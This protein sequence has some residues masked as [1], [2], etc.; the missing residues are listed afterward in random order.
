V[1]HHAILRAVPFPSLAAG[2]RSAR[3]PAASTTPRRADPWAA[4]GGRLAARAPKLLTRA[5]IGLAL[6][7]L[8]AAAALG[9]LRTAH[10]GRVYPAIHVADLALGGMPRAEAEAALQA[11][12]AAVEAAPVVFQHEGREW[13]SS[14]GELGVRVDAAAAFA[15]AY[16]LGR[17]ATALDRLRTTA[18]LIHDDEQ[19]PLPVRFD[20]A[21]L[22]RWY[23]AIDRELGLPPREARLAIDGAR[24]AIA[25]EI[26]GTVVDRA[27]A[28]EAIVGGLH[29]LRAFAGPLPTVAQPA[30]IRAADLEPARARLAAALAKPVQ[31]SFGEGVWSLPGADLARF[32]TQ[33]VDPTKRGAEALT[34][35]I[36]RPGLAA[37]L[38]ERL[39]PEINREPKDAVV[40]WGG[41]GL[42]S[43]EWSVDG[44]EL[45]AEPLAEAVERS[46]FGDHVPV[47][48]PV[49]ITPPA[50]DS[51]NLDKLGVVTLL[52]SGT[53]NY[54]GSTDGRAHNVE[55]GT[56][57]MNGTL[58]P[59]GGEFSFNHSIGVINEANGFVEAQV[60][61]G[62]QIGQDIGGGICQVSTTVF[63]AAYLAGLPIGEW[64]PHRF[65]I[66]FY[67][68]DGWAP[69]L[70]ASILQP[71]EDPSTWADFTFTNP[72]P[73]SWLLV[74]SWVAN[75]QVVVN[76]YGAD[77]GYTV[78][79]DGPTYGEK[80][81]MLPD[82]EIV[83]DELETGQYKQTQAAKEGEEL[84]HYRRV[85]DRDG[86][87]VSEKNFYTKFWPS[88]N[89][90]KVA[91][92]MKGKSPADPDRPLPPISKPTPS[93]AEIEE[94]EAG[95]EAQ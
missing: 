88:G 19:I 41:E 31:V 15:A 85:Y 27:R 1:R 44:V 86:N 58:V 20:R 37:W 83:D 69:G 59:P 53:S 62:E 64:H 7:L 54:S 17:E 33:E 92:D 2:P 72:S 14:L 74:E 3:R 32:V 91:P 71:T 35:G 26:D 75:G 89:V 21:A 29:E 28:T 51:N 4:A 57:R 82:K 22:D 34:I 55:V 66:G 46:L 80:F 90:W 84:S 47:E 23:D 45:Q 81:Q 67:E 56:W 95:A 48:A 9:L 43:V 70:D 25:P 12:A 6:L 11:R 61:D 78:E 40:G 42:D 63:R 13:R 30:R 73:D 5:V 68:L 87:L 38:E 60:I 10:E 94:T 52:G 93:P 50:I 39:A 36:D 77:F 24:V 65:R 76:I 79:S 16:G 8:V 49:E 18:G